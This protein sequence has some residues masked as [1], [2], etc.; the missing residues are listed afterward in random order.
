MLHGCSPK[1]RQKTKKFLKRK[2][3]VPVVTQWVRNPTSIRENVGLIPASEPPGD[4]MSCPIGHKC[5]C[6]IGWQR[7]LCSEPGNFHML[8]VWPWKEKR[9]RKWDP[10]GVRPKVT[11][12]RKLG[13]KKKIRFSPRFKLFL[14]P[15]LPKTQHCNHHTTSR[16]TCPQIPRTVIVKSMRTKSHS[17]TGMFILGFLACLQSLW[18]KTK[19]PS[20][21]CT[22]HAVFCFQNAQSDV[23]VQCCP[24]ERRVPRI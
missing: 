3:G 1:K 7:R 10:R 13:C 12:V 5:R 17:V 18:V 9:K 15:C 23:L 22:V 19:A 24:I 8:Q 4:A 20:S 2:W 6:G 21:F 16:V 14:R 11:K